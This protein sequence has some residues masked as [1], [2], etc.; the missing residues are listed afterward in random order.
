MNGIIILYMTP[1]C[2]Q[3][4][5]KTDNYSDRISLYEVEEFFKNSLNIDFQKEE[6]KIWGF[7]RS[8][9]VTYKHEEYA[10]F[11]RSPIFHNLVLNSQPV[12]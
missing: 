10:G 3:V 4:L 5:V 11:Q 7:L 12:Q 2:S 1:D 8:N 6:E 9:G